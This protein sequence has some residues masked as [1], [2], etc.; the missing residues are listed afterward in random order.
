MALQMF[1]Q[2]FDKIDDITNQYITN[3]SSNAIA[4]I[5]PII[6]VVLA[7]SFIIYGWLIMRGVVE[8]PFTEFISRCLRVSVI[9]SI[10]FSIGLSQGEINNFIQD[11]PSELSNVLTKNSVRNEK[12]YEPLNKAAVAGFQR[13]SEAFEESAFLNSDGFLY[14]LFGVLILIATS[15]VVAIGGAFI[16][17]A[18]ISLAFLFA[19][20]PFFIVALLW[21]TTHRFFERWAT[22]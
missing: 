16:L 20:G 1:T 4:T 21:Q 22:Q 9:I 14:G 19:L 17:L 18:K 11:I 8:L 5:A 15:S 2:L 10:A 7:I 6:S 12:F 13:A 3:I